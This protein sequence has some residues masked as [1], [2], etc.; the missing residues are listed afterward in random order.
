M[1]DAVIGQMGGFGVAGASV[2]AE[3]DWWAAGPLA[4]RAAE[5]QQQWQA[6]LQHWRKPGQAAGRRLLLLRRQ[7]L[8]LAAAAGQAE[9]VM[10]GEQQWLLPPVQMD[11]AM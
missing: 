5:E 4:W 9:A 7:V 6:E 8:L 11:P 1:V 3:Q 2:D 10:D